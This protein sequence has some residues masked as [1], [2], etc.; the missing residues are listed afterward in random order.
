M[1]FIC[2]YFEVHGI[3]NKNEKL[4]DRIY[5]NSNGH[6]LEVCRKLK[7]QDFWFSEFGDKPYYFF[8][9]KVSTYCKIGGNDIGE[10]E[11][12]LLDI[13]LYGPLKF[14]VNDIYDFNM[15]GALERRQRYSEMIEREKKNKNKFKIVFYFFQ[16]KYKLLLENRFLVKERLTTK[17]NLIVYIWYW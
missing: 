11:Y 4:F 9:N 12:Y 16:K 6:I 13:F 5:C 17:N 1:V 8:S 14:K 10:F 3:Y 7:T 2:L 15:I